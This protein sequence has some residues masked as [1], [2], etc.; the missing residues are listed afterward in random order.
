MMEKTAF[1]REFLQESWF[2]AAAKCD[3]AL[4]PS[5]V[6]QMIEDLGNPFC[7]GSHLDHFSSAARIR[8]IK[9]PARNLA[10]RVSHQDFLEATVAFFAR[11][12]T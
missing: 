5:S 2:Y 11:Q 1:P 9:I 6:E 12:D 4:L 7:L 3:R 10:G 8:V